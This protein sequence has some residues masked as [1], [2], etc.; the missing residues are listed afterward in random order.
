MTISEADTYIHSQLAAL[1][2][3]MHITL[4]DSATEL[5]QEGCGEIIAFAVS[6]YEK[7]KQKK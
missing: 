6:L 7:H 1:D 3:K 5:T 2:I 4:D